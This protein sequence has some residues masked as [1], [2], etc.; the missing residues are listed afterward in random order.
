MKRDDHDL[1]IAYYKMCKNLDETCEKFGINKHRLVRY[2]RQYS[3]S[4]FVD[5]RRGRAKPGQRIREIDNDEIVRLYTEEAYS[6]FALKRM[7]NISVHE[8]KKLFALRGVK[9]TSVRER[10]EQLGITSRSF[11]RRLSDKEKAQ[12]ID[13]YT[14][15]ALAAKF[16]G[17]VFRVGQRSI[18]KIVT[19]SGV[20]LSSVADRKKITPHHGDVTIH[21]ILS[22]YRCGIDIKTIDKFIRLQKSEII[23]I[24]EEHN[25]LVEAS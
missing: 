3:V 4:I 22:L 15:Y 12:I 8:L 19:D 23:E 5:P 21:K 1:L 18:D 16:L 14:N 6:I 11:P 10:A 17:Q 13:L 25:L 9:L 2:F 24:L 7:T 20:T